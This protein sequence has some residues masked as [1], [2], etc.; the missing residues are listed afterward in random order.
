M[1]EVVTEIWTLNEV[2]RK[3]LNRISQNNQS[4]S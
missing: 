2:A 3:A 4:K 1:H